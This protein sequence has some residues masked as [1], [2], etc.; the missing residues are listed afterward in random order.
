MNHHAQ[1]SL[2]CRTSYLLHLK[3]LLVAVPVQLL[4]VRG[5]CR[6]N[7]PAQGARC[8][9][10]KGWPWPC[11]VSGASTR[12]RSQV[13]RFFRWAL[14]GWARLGGWKGSIINTLSL[15]I[16]IYTH[17]YILVGGFKHFLFSMIYGM[18]SFPLTF[19]F[20]KVVKTC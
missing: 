19:I 5:P 1:L 8:H 4:R 9:G 12:L 17:T 11:P 20:F 10:G 15:S 7:A 3:F 2:F 16:Y 18:S 14:E 6:A 13:A